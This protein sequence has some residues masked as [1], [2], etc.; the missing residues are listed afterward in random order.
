[1]T[2]PALTDEQREAYR[3][4]KR[5]EAEQALDRLLTQEGW[6]LWLRLRRGLHSY[7][8]GNQALIAMQAWTQAEMAEVG[9]PHAPLVPCSKEPTIVKAA[10]KW[11]RDGFHP[12]RGSRGLHVWVFKTRRRKDKSWVCCGQRR[13]ERTCPE[14]SR[15]DHYFTLGPTFDASQVVSFDTGER[16]VVELP[17]SMPIEGDDPGGWL[18]DELVCVA[19]REDWCS[20]IGMNVASDHGERGWYKP[21]DRTIGICPAHG[22]A[23]LR[24]LIHE[25]AHALGVHSVKLDLTYAEC[26]VAVECVSFMVASTVGLDTSG[27]SIPYIAG[28]GGA[29]ARDKVRGL[30]QLIDATA[31]KIEGPLLELVAAREA[32]AVMA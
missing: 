1:M 18:V 24:T 26:E 29:E 20:S 21:A 3:E 13:M 14:C 23:Q 7:S 31:K 27:E 9:H 25:L 16:P 17:P 6:E 2:R 28:W 5:N 15:Q 19:L 8:W 32:E 22:N 10:W 12:A 30:A 11:K 4:A